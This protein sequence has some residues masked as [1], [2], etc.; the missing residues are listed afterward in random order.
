MDVDK[1]IKLAED[2]A[3][4]FKGLDRPR[5]EWNKWSEYYR[6][7]KDLN[8]S[9]SLA[10]KLSNSPML[11]DNPQKVYKVITSTIKS[12]MTT[13]KNL[14]SEE[15]SQIFGFVSWKLTSFEAKGE[16]GKKVEK[17]PRGN[18]RRQPRRG[19]RGYR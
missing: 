10:E 17:S 4:T 2:I 16:G 14:S 6:R 8:K 12:K 3:T 9:L 15:I 19:N 18:F 11:R 13:F 1:I 5:T 7:T